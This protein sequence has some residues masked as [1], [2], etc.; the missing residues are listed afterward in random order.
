[1][2]RQLISLPII[3]DQLCLYKD[4]DRIA[5][6]LGASLQSEKQPNIFFF[7]RGVPHNLSGLLWSTPERKFFIME[8][9]ELNDNFKIEDNSKEIEELKA[10]NKT[11]GETASRV[12]KE[13]DTALLELSGKETIH[14]D[15]LLEIVAAA[16]GKKLN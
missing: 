5:E 9:S 10:A 12:M 16:H 1:M 7:T 8:Y 11:L 2:K 15:L 6:L 3:S 13:R 4:K 14:K